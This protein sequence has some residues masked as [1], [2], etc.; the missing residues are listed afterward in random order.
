MGIRISVRI[1]PGPSCGLVRAEVELACGH[2]AFAIPGVQH[3]RRA[4]C[5]HHGRQILRRIGLAQRT[6]DGAAIA[7]DRIGDHSL[8]LG[9]DGVVLAGHSR[10]QQLTMS[11]HGADAN[12]VAFDADVGQVEVVDVDEMFGSGESKLHHRQQAVPS[13]NQPGL[14]PEPFQQRNG[15]VDAGRSLV[16]ERRWNLHEIP[17]SSVAPENWPHTRRGPAPSGSWAER[18][19][20]VNG[21]LSEGLS[22]PDRACGG[23]ST[24]PRL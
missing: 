22:R 7:H 12:L 14:G 5:R 4:Q 2:G 13:G 16:F 11:C 19:A 21:L 24:V 9:E 6:A 17:R 1:S 23:R 18:S 8:G 15:V 20:I 10:L 3:D